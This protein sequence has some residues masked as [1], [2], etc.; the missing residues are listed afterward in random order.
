MPILT[1]HSVGHELFLVILLDG[2]QKTSVL[3]SD[4]NKTE[5]KTPQGEISSELAC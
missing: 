3:N 1:I 2:P 5:K 4:D